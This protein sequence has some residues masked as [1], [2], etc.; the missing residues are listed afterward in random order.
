MSIGETK[1]HVLRRQWV[2]LVRRTNAGWIVSFNGRQF[3]A[4][5]LFL[6]DYKR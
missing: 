2:S 1:W 3:Q 4:S 6:W 5:E